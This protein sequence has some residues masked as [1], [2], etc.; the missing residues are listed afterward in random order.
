MNKIQTISCSD[1][2]KNHTI[3]SDPQSGEMTC[4]SCG[5]VFDNIENTTK[6][7]GSNGDYCAS[8][9]IKKDHAIRTRRPISLARHDM[10]LATTI[11]KTDRDAHG[12]VLDA[13]MRTAMNRLRTWDF[14]SQSSYGTDRNLRIAFR[15]LEKLKDTLGLS[16]AAV[17][18]TAY[19]YRKAQERGL[20]RGRTIHAMLAAAAY[21]ACREMGVSKT[22][23]DIST[24]ANITRKDLS[25]SY[26]LLIIEL[27][28]KIP[29]ID[30]AKCISKIA[31]KMGL[32]ETT[33]RRALSIMYEVT[34]NEISAGKDPMG[35]AAAVLYF[36]NT[37]A[38]NKPVTQR[39]MASAAGITEVTLR[40]RFKELRSKLQILN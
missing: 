30:P 32:R 19:I 15:V 36:A 40:N 6:L 7:L 29:L 27:D 35:L 31:N 1:Y 13:Q 11:C 25:R 24:A 39:C 37:S 14:R 38:G 20:V 8:S 21:I 10:G 33:K 26:R 9:I 34:K 18:K 28:L 12:K 22:L 16:D 3:I 2:N 17:E 4:N 23:N 5:I